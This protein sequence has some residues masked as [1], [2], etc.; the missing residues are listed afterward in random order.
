[1]V[2]KHRSFLFCRAVIAWMLCGCCDVFC[3][4]LW[5]LLRVSSSLSRQTGQGQ[6]R[7]SVRIGRF[8]LE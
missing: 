2:A 7:S 8:T 1:V 4:L 6:Q 5:S 3:F